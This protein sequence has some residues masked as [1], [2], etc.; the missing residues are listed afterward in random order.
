MML[1][2]A[3]PFCYESYQLYKSG[4]RKYFQ[5]FWNYI[6]FAF[7]WLGIINIFLQLVFNQFNFVNKV[8]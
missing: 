3:Y 2:I 7:V 5:S 8:F 4:W 6:H 1:G